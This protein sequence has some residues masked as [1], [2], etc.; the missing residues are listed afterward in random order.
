MSQATQTAPRPLEEDI[1]AMSVHN[2]ERM[3]M[4]DLIFERFELSLAKAFRSFTSAPTE[5]ELLDVHYTTYGHAMLEVSD[6][7]MIGI[8][9]VMPWQGPVAMAMD[10]GFLYAALEVIMGG[11]A[12]GTPEKASRGF[13]RIETRIANRLCDLAFEDLAASFAQVADLSFEIKRME[14]T[15]QLATITQ[16][17]SA[18]VKADFRIVFGK[19]SGT[20]SLILPQGSL[21]PIRDQLTKV[22]YGEKLGGDTEWRGHLMEQI[23]QSHLSVTAVLSE[24]RLPL[25]EIMQ[26]RPGQVIDLMTVEDDGAT[27]TCVGVPIAR[28]PTGH[29]ANG[30]VAVRVTEDLGT[31]AAIGP[32]LTQTTLNT[33]PMKGKS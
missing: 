30:A 19:A 15:A 20:M 33:L 26:W 2:F 31:L 14:A 6:P 13:T 29:C 32:M 1:I 16:P 8:A 23:A 7:C 12:T 17:G 25:A 9:D 5:A 27:L 3:P 4:L 24:V 11:T 10:A 28:G 22:F 21:T 18:C